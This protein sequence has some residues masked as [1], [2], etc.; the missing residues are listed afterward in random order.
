MRRSDEPTRCTT[1]IDWRGWLV[2]AWAL[3]FGWQ[4]AQMVVEQR[5]SK[6]RSL[7]TGTPTAPEP[8]GPAHPASR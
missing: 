1:Q 6:A 3:W 2:L 4:Y 5:G 7:V 8:T